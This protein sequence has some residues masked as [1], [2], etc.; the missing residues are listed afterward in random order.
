[1]KKKLL[2]F[3]SLGCDKNRVDSEYMLSLLTEKEFSL[4]MDPGEAELI[5]VNSC[6][7]IG[8]A[9]EESIETILSMAE[10][11]ETGC[12][13]GLIVTGCLSQRYQDEVLQEMP[14]VDAI[15]GTNSWDAIL[16]VSLKVLGGEKEACIRDLTGFP[17]LPKRKL[18][19]TG[20]GT[21]YLKIAEGC[22][23]R[24]TYCIIPYIRG[25]YRSV[26][27]EALLSEAKDLIALGARELI[28][29]AQETTLYG[30]DLYGEK[31]LGRLLDE[32]SSLPEL[33][34]IRILY[35]YPEEIDQELIDAIKRNDKVCHYLDL[36]IQH[37]SDRI[38]KRMARKTESKELKER[39]ALLR[40]EI[41]D[42]VLRTT[43]ITGFPGETEEDFERLLSFTEEMR[44][45]RLG[46]FCY[47]PEEGTPAF[48]EAD[49]VPEALREERRDA[50]MEL[51]R[52]ITFEKNR[53]LIGKTLTVLVEG[54]I[55]EEEVYI[56]RTYRDAPEV[57]GYLFFPYE[58]ELLSGTFA[59]VLVTKTDGYDILGELTETDPDRGNA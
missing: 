40:R 47:S 16:E 18:L 13:R 22:N 14:E 1:M 28:L 9:K 2:Y 51:Q 56:G 5:I 41:P 17:N 44:F 24:C 36:P 58:G 55:P 42:I 31:S 48:E 25:D 57:D 50:L 19:T 39:I 30:V 49:Q 11:K 35:C 27:M 12:C 43:M 29:V 20:A 8:D 23:K 45:D 21:A 38:L 32:L 10:Y 6:S 26:P 59:E 37:A 7:F 46:A 52:E 15:L 4:T 3:V 34:W 54:R 53:S 33:K